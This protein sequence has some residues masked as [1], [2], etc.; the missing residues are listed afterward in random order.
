MWFPNMWFP[1][2][3]RAGCPRTGARC[4]HILSASLGLLLALLLSGCGGGGGSTTDEGFRFVPDGSG[5]VIPNPN[6]QFNYD[7][8]SVTSGVIVTAAPVP[9]GAAPNTT[10][11]LQSSAY[12]ITFST[13]TVTF[14]PQARIYLT[15]TPAST[16]SSIPRVYLYTPGAVTGSG[17]Q[18]L[19]ISI[20]VPAPGTNTL[21]ALLP[22]VI[23]SGSIV[24]V[25]A[26]T[27]P[28]VSGTPPTPVTPGTPGTPISISGP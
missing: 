23:K 3:L 5:P 8:G 25:Y 24:A 12:Q 9:A 4:R 26:D 10:A 27:P 19:P 18:A 20:I 7:A 17:W 11:V 21:E 28:S 22:S 6:V 14:N 16:P 1:K 13:P 2:T 15:F